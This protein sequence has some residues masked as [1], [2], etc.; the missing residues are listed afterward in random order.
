MSTTDTVNDQRPSDLDGIIRG[1]RSVRHLR[2]DPVPRAMVE[3]VLEAGRWAPSPHG[4]QPWRFVVLTRDD[5]KRR[6]ADA[7]ADAWERNLAMDSEPPETIAKRLAGSRRRLLEAPVL[8]L[9]CL[10]TSDLDHYPDPER[11]VAE[12]TMAIQSL[13][14]C[15]QNMLLKAYSLGLDMGWMC[16]PLF[17]PDVAR[18]ALGLPGGLI[19]HALFPL[20][21]AAADPKRRPRRPLTELVVSWQ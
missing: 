19:P 8:I 2:S 10:D 9:L 15:A 6:L 14:A 5:V 20:G 7:M 17:C 21:Y 3:Q 16:A 11:Q 18:D 1:R 12:M 4:T 13:G